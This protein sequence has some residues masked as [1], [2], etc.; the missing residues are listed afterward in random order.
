MA[1]QH[2]R[3]RRAR[4]LGHPDA[5]HAARPA[6]AGSDPTTTTH[7]HAYDLLAAGFGDGFNGP[8]LI[9]VDL[10]DNPDPTV[11]DD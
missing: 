4:D 2:R 3:H 6:D 9:A 7:R 11:L 8:L 10:G 5:R 1:F